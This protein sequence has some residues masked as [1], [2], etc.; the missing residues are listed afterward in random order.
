MKQKNTVNYLG[1]VLKQC[2][3]G[4][5]MAASAIQK[6]NVRLK[7]FIQKGEIFKFD[8]QKAFSDVFDTKSF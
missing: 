6:A 2:L 4:T 1:V 8:N 7:F 3:S 5:N